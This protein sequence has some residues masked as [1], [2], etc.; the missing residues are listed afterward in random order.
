MPVGKYRLDRNVCYLHW[1]KNPLGFSCFY[2]SSCSCLGRCMYSYIRA[3][4]VDNENWMFCINWSR[5]LGFLKWVLRVVKYRYCTL[6]YREGR[7]EWHLVY[8]LQAGDEW[9][10]VLH[11]HR[12]PTRQLRR[13]GPQPA[14]RGPRGRAQMRVFAV[15]LREE[16][17]PARIS[18]PKHFVP[19]ASERFAARAGRRSGSLLRHAPVGRMQHLHRP[20]PGPT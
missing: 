6:I 12:R 11:R 9:G 15:L 10:R 16:S 5:D 1:H 4:I 13:D 2:V 17:N 19:R 20:R 18:H 8:L 3:V 7:K 14:S